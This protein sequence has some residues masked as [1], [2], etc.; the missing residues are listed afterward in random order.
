[1]SEEKHTK[2]PWRVGQN[3]YDIEQDNKAA[4]AICLIYSGESSKANAQLIAAAT[5]LLEALKYCE[6]DLSAA[7]ELF[8]E[9]P[10]CWHESIRDARA[11]IAKATS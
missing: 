5:E 2:G 4:F 3:G 9:I 6:A 7:E 1:M 8:G 11:A 10:K